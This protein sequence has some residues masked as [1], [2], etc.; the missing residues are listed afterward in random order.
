M[1]LEQE[2][3]GKISTSEDMKIDHYTMVAGKSFN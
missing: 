1:A 2:T 3:K